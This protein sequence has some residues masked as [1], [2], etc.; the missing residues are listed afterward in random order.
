MFMTSGLGIRERLAI[1]GSVDDVNTRVKVEEYMRRL[2]MITPY[3][4]PSRN[5]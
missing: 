1:S 5:R 2:A 3:P 4:S